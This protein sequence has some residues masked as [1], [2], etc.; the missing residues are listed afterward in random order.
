M[1]Y[2]CNIRFCKNLNISLYAIVILATMLKKSLS[3]QNSNNMLWSYC[4]QKMV[5]TFATILTIRY[6][7]WKLDQFCPCVESYAPKL[8]QIWIYKST[9]VTIE[10]LISICIE[11]I[12][13]S[14]A[15]SS[16][17]TY[18][19][20]SL[21]IFKTK[22]VLST[23]WVMMAIMIVFSDYKSYWSESSV[24]SITAVMDTGINIA[25]ILT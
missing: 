10:K 15:V 8:D 2:L 16:N 20:L 9:I 19:S 3:L 21:S 4:R 6:L 11:L 18:I 14:W 24:V 5:Q 13:N 12:S 22:P 23:S 1:C 25:F 7:L 17:W